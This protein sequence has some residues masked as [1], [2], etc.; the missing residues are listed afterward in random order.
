MNDISFPLFKSFVFVLCLYPLYE[1]IWYAV[2]GRFD[3]YPEWQIIG[4]T[5]EAA[6]VFLLITLSVTPLRRQFGWMGRYGSDPT[7]VPN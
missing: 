2:T 1:L 4:F 5:G 6:L 7:E 3:S